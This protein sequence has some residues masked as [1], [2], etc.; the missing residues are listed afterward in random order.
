ML[1]EI[2]QV[3]AD[4][5]TKIICST[6]YAF[7]TEYKGGFDVVIG[8]PP[9]VRAE[10]IAQFAEYFQNTYKTFQPAADLFTYFYEKGFSILKLNGL[11]AFISNTFDKTKAAISLREWLKNN[12]TLLKYVDFT[13][14]QIFEG[15]TTYPIILI[16][17]NQN[18]VN[19][20]FQYIKITKGNE[21]GIDF[22]VPSNLEQVNLENDNWAFG[23]NQSSEIIRKLQLHPYIKEKYGKCYYGVKTALNEAFLIPIRFFNNKE[24]IKPIFEGKE[25]SKWTNNEQVQS[26][27]LFK[28][29]W[30]K[31]HFGNLS[32]IDA[33]G[34]I[35]DLFP[36]IFN[37]LLPFE[38]KA[39]ARYDKGEYWWELRNCAYYHLFEKPKIIFPNLQN[40]NKFSLDESGVYINAPAV[41]LS[42][43][44][45][46]NPVQ[47][48]K[49]V[50]GILNSKLIWYFLKT[51]CVVRS[52]GYIEVKPQY[53]E[54]I[55]IPAIQDDAQNTISEKIDQLLILNKELQECSRKFKG[56]LK[57]KFIFKD[58]P[59][60]L[61]D[62]YLLS[63][64]QFIMELGKK[65]IK[66]S[67][68]DEAEWEEYFL[69]E[70]QKALELKSQIEA[71]D[72]EIDQMVY[73]LYDLTDEEIKIV[74]NA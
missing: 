32:E 66:L 68:K 31:A 61:N 67:L 63:Y 30:T 16:A 69:L 39:K 56:N 74:E 38:Q 19:N 55:P 42:L 1:H 13:D 71:T 36:D 18:Q 40:S 37:H 50:L 27:I 33:L 11:F 59:R 45:L 8:N 25:L 21:D 41:M 26:L 12:A 2:S 54:Q 72:Q 22:Y 70:S 20:Q 6:E 15:A 29:K 46:Q 4:S 35:K 57:R 5:V 60:K 43:S 10:L 51:I 65:K 53:F 28:S 7:R 24:I 47:E 34:K 14:V 9:Y 48:G 58:L 44:H 23:N 3:H 62:W 73:K 49:F 52:G 17:K 64:G